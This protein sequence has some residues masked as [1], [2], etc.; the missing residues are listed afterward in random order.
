MTTKIPKDRVDKIC[1]DEFT[2]LLLQNGSVSEF[3]VQ[4]TKKIIA[5]TTKS[6]NFDVCVQTWSHNL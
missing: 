5:K 6:P 1:R 3:Y 4:S 2:K